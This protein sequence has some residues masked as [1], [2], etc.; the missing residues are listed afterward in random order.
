MFRQ[1]PLT[2]GFLEGGGKEASVLGVV[3]RN[4]AVTLEAE[5]DH[6]VEQANDRGC[7]PRAVDKGDGALAGVLHWESAVGG[8]TYKF[9]LKLCS[10]EPYAVVK[11]V[12]V[13]QSMG[14]T[15][16][17]AFRNARGR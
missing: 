2:F 15:K 14:G 3:Q 5:L 9:K 7:R 11:S 16:D 4:L 6:V 17:N 1:C 10:T 12:S 8:S 13:W